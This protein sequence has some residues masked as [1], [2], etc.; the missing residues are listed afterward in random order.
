LAYT[1]D[2][3]LYPMWVAAH[4]IMIVSPVHWYQANLATGGGSAGGQDHRCRLLQ[5]PI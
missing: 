2:E 4:G 1:D 5:S 3:R